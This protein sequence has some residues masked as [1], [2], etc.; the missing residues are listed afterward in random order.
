[1]SWFAKG[2]SAARKNV[3]SMLPK[4]AVGVEIGVWKGDFSAQIL[5]YGKPRALH[6]VDPWLTSEAADRT[7]Q[8]WYGAGQITQEAMDTI[9]QSVVDRFA[10]ETAAGRVVIHRS[11]S[12]QA[13]G[14]MDADS[15]DYVY[16]DGDHSYDGVTTD[17]AEAFR[18]TRIDGFLCCDDYLL[19][20][21][22]KDGVVRA[23]HE[24]LVAKPVTIHYKSN[25]QVVL[26]KVA[27]SP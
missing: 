24:L 12:R 20:A 21:W 18:V 9:Q 7:D 4:D 23:V 15:V 19:G 16:V 5:R 11:D 1:M 13:L 27:S 2:E 14:N 25:T 3:L 22:W 17:L 10:G 6:L 26:R 8:A